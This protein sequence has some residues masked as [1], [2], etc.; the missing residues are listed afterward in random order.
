M[1]LKVLKETGTIGILADYN[2]IPGEGVFVDFF[3]KQACTTSGIARVALHTDA[4]V[5]PGHAYCY[6]KVGAKRLAVESLGGKGSTGA[7]QRGGLVNK[8][9][10]YKSAR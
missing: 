1:M 10:V 8:S 2:T 5:V 3:G 9:R 6:Q 7:K 4:A